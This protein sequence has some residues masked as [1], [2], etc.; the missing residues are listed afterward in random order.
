[1]FNDDLKKDKKRNFIMVA[2]VFV[3]MMV[4]ISLD[5]VFKWRSAAKLGE[6]QKGNRQH[7]FP[8]INKPFHLILEMF[9][10]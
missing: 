9:L 1:M 3:C 7:F 4:M 5:I 2:I 8:R 10:K 6:L